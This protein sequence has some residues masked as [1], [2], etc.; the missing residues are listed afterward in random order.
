MTA[1]GIE[2]R[3]KMSPRHL[4]RDRLHPSVVAEGHSGRLDPPAERVLFL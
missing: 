4:L 3:D 2:R 1:D